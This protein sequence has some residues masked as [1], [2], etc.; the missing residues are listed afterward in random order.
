MQHNSGTSVLAEFFGSIFA[1]LTGQ[2]GETEWCNLRSL[3]R[4]GESENEVIKRAWPWPRLEKKVTFG[5]LSC[6][7]A[8]AV[9]RID[10]KRTCICPKSF[11]CDPIGQSTIHSCVKLT[12][13]VHQE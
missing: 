12:Y 13:F 6:S 1:I 4:Q 10:G 3:L 7:G 8:G 9:C 11:V 2:R 5:L